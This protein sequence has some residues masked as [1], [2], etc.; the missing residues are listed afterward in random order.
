MQDGIVFTGVDVGKAELV[1]ARQ[2][3]D[4]QQPNGQKLRLPNTDSSILKWLRTLPPGSHIAMESTGRYHQRLALLAYQ[5]GMKVYVLNAR[6]VHFYAK[7]LGMRG[8]TD[9]SDAL[10]IARYVAEH[11]EKL[12]LWGPGTPEQRRLIEMLRRRAAIERHLSAID[13]S[14]EDVVDL[15][16][17]K[18][19]M[20]RYAAKLLAT[21]DAKIQALIASDVDLFERQ[22]RLQTIAGVGPQ[23]SAVLAA[24]LS[25]NEF[26][27]VG[28]VI[29]YSGLDPRPN[30]SGNKRGRRALSKRGPAALR[31]MLW[32]AA[33]SAS[34]SK[35]FKGAY[36]SIK[37]RGFSGTEAL[38]ILARKLLRV[39]WAVW[40]TGTPF[41]P[42]KV[43]PAA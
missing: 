12:R 11:H 3:S 20:A 19:S 27:N 21:I 28:A 25:R 10:V 31:K 26:A 34:R 15:A 6:D 38:V 40:R 30:D 7:A 33:F 22:Q 18:A 29:A 41:E 32:L 36:Q 39:A 17:Q 9:P 23:I 8:K 35:A 16:R 1:V 37:N 43:Q 24:V 5:A 2:P 4:R 13:D 14:L 42:A